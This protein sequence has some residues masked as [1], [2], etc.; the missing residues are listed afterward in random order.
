MQT[1]IPKR[2]WRK[3]A[4]ASARI[5]TVS[6]YPSRTT[7]RP[8]SAATVLTGTREPLRPTTRTLHSSSSTLWLKEVYPELHRVDED[9][10][11]KEELDEMERCHDCGCTDFQ[12]N[13]GEEYYCGHGGM[14]PYRAHDDESDIFKAKEALAEIL[15]QYIYIQLGHRDWAEKPKNSLYQIKP[16]S[17]RGCP[18]FRY[19]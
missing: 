11:K 9:G 17:K 12:L 10:D 15:A 19:A 14:S 6:I 16:C 13:W 8:A 18:N 5:V 7:G 2:S 1:A 3:S 4:L